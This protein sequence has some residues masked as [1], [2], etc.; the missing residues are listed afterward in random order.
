MKFFLFVGEQWLLVSILLMLVY[1]YLLNE[2]RKSGKA[3]G[4]H[5]L[6]ELLN[7]ENAVLVDLR[8]SGDFNQ[9]HIQGAINIPHTKLS[10]RCVELE[11]KK[12]KIIVL[13]DQYGQHASAAGKLLR[14]KDFDVRRLSGG[15]MEWRDQ[16]MP[17]VRKK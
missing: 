15:M 7:S 8:P 2:R 6:V 14:S 10:A 13:A 3:V 17:L 5:E 9:G 12:T 11:G 1:A 16:N 4:T